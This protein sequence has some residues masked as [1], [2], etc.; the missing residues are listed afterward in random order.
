MLPPSIQMAGDAGGQGLTA[1]AKKALKTKSKRSKEEA[2]SDLPED[3][4]ASEAEAFILKLQKQ[5]QYY[6]FAFW[7]WTEIL[8]QLEFKDSREN[9][10]AKAWRTIVIGMVAAYG[11]I[12]VI[13]I[14]LA[15]KKAPHIADTYLPLSPFLGLSIHEHK[16]SRLLRFILNYTT[17]GGT[18]PTN[19][20]VGVGS[21][22]ATVEHASI[23]AEY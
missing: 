21:Y 23:C 17:V 19:D 8:T 7:R 5:A 20:T 22:S 3:V 4:E 10:A 16:K 11:V 18:I 15:F 2:E 9:K 12:F 14:S 6:Q 1:V 13:I